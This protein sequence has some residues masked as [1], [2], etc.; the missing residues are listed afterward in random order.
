MYTIYSKENCV[1]CKRAKFFLESRNL[2]YIEF[3]IEEMNYQFEMN[4]K[5]GYTAKTV[6][7]IWE[8]DLHIGG[9]T[10]LVEYKKDE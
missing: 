7:Q 5:L 8:D 4:Q 6:P 1:F 10:E 3:N 2:D 9:Y